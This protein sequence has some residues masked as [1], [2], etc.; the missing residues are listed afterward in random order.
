MSTAP[1]A[2]AERVTLLRSCRLPTQGDVQGSDGLESV[3]LPELQTP[4]QLK[5]ERKCEC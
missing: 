1:S 5:A 3:M 4:D 2:R